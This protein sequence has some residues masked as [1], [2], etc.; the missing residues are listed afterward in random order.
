MI[1]GFVPPPEVARLIDRWISLAVEQIQREGW[2]RSL[3]AESP[4][5]SES[6][7]DRVLSD[8]TEPSGQNEPS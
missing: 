6:W 8:Q 3:T 1:S 7:L 4:K 2:S 5:D